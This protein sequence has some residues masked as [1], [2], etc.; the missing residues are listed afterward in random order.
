L[1]SIGLNGTYFSPAVGII[2]FWGDM[3]RYDFSEEI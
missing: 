3:A 1:I 2:G